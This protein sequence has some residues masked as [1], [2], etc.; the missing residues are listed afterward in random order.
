MAVDLAAE[1]LDDRPAAAVGVTAVADDR[2]RVDLLATDQDVEPHEV[3]G[4]VAHQFVV[5][6]AV[7]PRHALEL[8]VEIVDHL[9]ERQIEG[10]HRPRRREVFGLE[11]NAAA[12][13]A[14]LHHR[15]DLLDRHEEVGPHDRLE[16]L[17]DLPGVGHILRVGDVDRLAGRLLDPVG[18][19]GRGLDK[20]EVV[21]L[22]QPLLDDLHV[23][24]PKEATAEAEAEGLAA[25][26]G[27]FERGIVDRQLFQRVAEFFEVL[28]FARIEAAV[29]H[30]LRRLV[31][32][33]GCSGMVTRDRHGVADVHLLDVLD[34]AHQVAHLARRE[35]LAG[36]PLRDELAE[37][38]HLVG[39]ARLQEADFLP[40]GDR[41]VDEPHVGDRAAVAV[42]VAVKDQ[43]PQGRVGIALG[44]WN[45]LDDRGQEVVDPDAGLGAGLDHL[46]GFDGEALL[47]LTEHLVHPG[48]HEIDLVD[49]RHD[50]QIQVDRRV[51]IG[52]RLGLD[53][54]K[55]IDEQQRA[56]AAREAPGNLVVEV[57]VPRRVDQVELV[58]LPLVPVFHP[59]RPGLD[60]DPTLPLELHVVEHLLLELTLFHRAG[61]LQ[62]PVGQ[63]ALAM[64]D[65]GDDRKIADVLAV[66]GGI[67]PRM[68]RF[69]RS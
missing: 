15:A 16:K 40:L 68:A 24:E 2:E 60:R 41:A 46:R 54:L 7:A 33:H 23:E 50:R 25:L 66:H 36:P 63:R 58:Q 51:G 22:L 48:V 13:C 35:R 34:V 61:R 49:H 29:N 28:P 45:P 44:G 26:R 11:I 38:E 59:H 39:C 18:D 65:V 19:V 1:L 27:V 20:V 55:G 21:L 56:F 4:E 64:V 12:V 37:F 62:Q 67:V 53:S 30:P 42:V 52:H 10:D 3:G 32:R 14:E 17:V 43:R 6:R 69:S 31:A 9:A 57:D 5:H 8:V 47:H